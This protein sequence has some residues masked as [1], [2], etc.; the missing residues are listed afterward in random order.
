VIGFDT[1]LVLHAVN[2]S[3]MKR[4]LTIKGSPEKKQAKCRAK[5][6]CM[7]INNSL[8]KEQFLLQIWFEKAV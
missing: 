1:C 7:N 6:G 8:A 4:L 3:D 5:I 2:S